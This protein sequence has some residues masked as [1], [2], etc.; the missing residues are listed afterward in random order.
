MVPGPWFFTGTYWLGKG[1]AGFVPWAGEC[2]EVVPPGTEP[3]A[4][5]QTQQGGLG[6]SPGHSGEK[7]YLHGEVGP[8]VM[9]KMDE[10]WGP[11]PAE[12]TARG[13]RSGL[14]YRGPGQD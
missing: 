14:D 10:S 8:G 4:P 5:A 11:Q 7:L 13:T 9:D 3:Q 2:A 6:G 1:W 12:G